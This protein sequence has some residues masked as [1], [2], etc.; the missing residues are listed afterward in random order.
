MVF[1]D[2]EMRDQ[3]YRNAE[4]Y[5]TGKYDKS[6][7]TDMSKTEE[8]VKVG[9]SNKIKFEEY[10]EDGGYSA[11]TN[12]VSTLYPEE[13]ELFE[14]LRK[15]LDSQNKEIANLKS[16]LILS[17]DNESEEIEKLKDLLNDQTDAVENLK[18]I[19]KTQKDRLE[20]LERLETEKE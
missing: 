19:V 5:Q 15:F 10:W 17:K 8:E 9:E 11:T 1:K 13:N 4:Q 6:A 16:K 20:K 12:K 2:F 3:R 18:K 7:Q 14:E